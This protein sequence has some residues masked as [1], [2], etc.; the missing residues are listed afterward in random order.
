MY[1]FEMQWRLVLKN[2]GPSSLILFFSSSERLVKGI[3]VKIK[4]N[5]LSSGDIALASTLISTCLS[6]DE[7][8]LS[9]TRVGPIT[10]GQTYQNNIDSLEQQKWEEP[11]PQRQF[12]TSQLELSLKS[13]AFEKFVYLHT[14]SLV[15]H[16]RTQIWKKYSWFSIN[17]DITNSRILWLNDF[18]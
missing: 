2:S 8:L 3:C 4:P 6:T 1:Y 7:L 11:A 16:P 9:G 14:H 5:V 15:R 10:R 13:H 17:Y 12:E 18:I